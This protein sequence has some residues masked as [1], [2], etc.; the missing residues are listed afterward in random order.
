[1]C[2]RP[3]NILVEQ[4]RSR[5]HKCGLASLPAERCYGTT[6]PREKACCLNGSA[7]QWL[8]G[9]SLQSW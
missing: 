9:V 7:A 1:M 2:P 4:E 3:R 8:K 6:S 5:Q